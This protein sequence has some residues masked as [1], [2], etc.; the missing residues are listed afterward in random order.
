MVAI[1]GMTIFDAVELWLYSEKNQVLKINVYFLY[2]IFVTLSVLLFKNTKLSKDLYVVAAIHRDSDMQEWTSKSKY[3]RLSY[4]Q[5]VPGHCLKSSY[6]YW[7]HLYN[8]HVDGSV[9]YPRSEFAKA[10]GVQT[11]FGVPLPGH[12][13]SCG[14][15]VLYSKLAVLADPLMVTLV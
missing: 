6:P 11:A 14:A 7:D 15:L 1:I 2:L 3:L 9:E 8:T 12:K 5:D 4:G 10:L 13:G